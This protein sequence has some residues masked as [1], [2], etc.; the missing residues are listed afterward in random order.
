MWDRKR[1]VILSI[2]V[3]FAFALV[4]AL[5]LFFAPWMVTR[6]LTA[7]RGISVDGDEIDAIA[8]RLRSEKKK[9]EKS[10]EMTDE[11]FQNYLENLKKKGK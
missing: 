2:V 8:E 11:G 9:K 6:I 1:S 7:Y 5:G 3:C 4:L 10:G